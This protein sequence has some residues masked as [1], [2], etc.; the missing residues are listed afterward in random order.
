MHDTGDGAAG[1]EVMVEV[2]VYPRSGDDGIT[3][4][5][6]SIVR[7]LFVDI[8]IGCRIPVV[9]LRRQ[10]GVVGTRCAA[11]EGRMFKLD[12]QRQNH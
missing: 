7:Y 6:G 1:D 10:L 11:T 3:Q 8:A 12:A 2:G 5:C 9:S 4:R